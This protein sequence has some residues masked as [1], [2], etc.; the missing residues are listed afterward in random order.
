VRRS[1]PVS[2]PAAMPEPSSAHPARRALVGA[3]PG[4]LL[5]DPGAPPP[6][7]RVIAYSK[8]ELLAVELRTADEVEPLRQ[9]F[10]VVWLNVD[11]LGDGTVLRRL[12][13][14]FGLHRLALEDVTSRQQ[15][16]KLEDYQT[17]D[18]LVLR[19]TNPG[20]ELDTEQ[21]S[22]FVG[23][24]FVLT[25]Q[26][27]AGDAFELIRTRLRDPQGRLRQSGPDYLAYAL[28]DASVDA[29]FP[30]LERIGDRL[31][32]CEEHILAD[33]DHRTAV[34]EIHELRRDLLQLRRALWPLREVTAALLRET[35]SRFGSDTRVYLRDVHD[36]V[37]QLLDLLE[38]FREMG[39]SLMEVH[40]STVSNRLNE[41]MKV[42]TIIATIFIPLTF[43]AGVYG[44][45]FKH[46]PEYE[47]EWGYP[48][49]LLLMA[50]IAAAM[51]WWFRRRR[52]L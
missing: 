21:L 37:V 50:A 23:E 42:L 9:R 41:V 13:E 10:P 47:W 17:N 22:L 44:M 48:V 2:P 24:G 28:I 11:G 16:A 32:T 40:L 45:N 29:Y 36:H 3:S 49:C 8:D 39:S 25:F 34:A 43:V 27:R 52:W 18:F 33:C 51:L 35:C 1:E 31:D 14:L 38:N 6:L 4:T 20:D 46:M 12:G 30:V 15:R 26:E 19:V 5:V 7:L